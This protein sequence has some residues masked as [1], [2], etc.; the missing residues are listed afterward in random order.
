MFL[1]LPL[2][3]NCKRLLSLYL[4]QFCLSLRLFGQLL[5]LPSLCLEKL[6]LL[7]AEGHQLLGLA[8]LSQLLWRILWLT[9]S[10][11]LV[12]LRRVMILSLSLRMILSVV[13][14]TILSRRLGMI[15]TLTLKSMLLV[16]LVFVIRL[17]LKV[18]LFLLK[19]TKVWIIENL[20][21]LRLL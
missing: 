7:L 19:L 16:L 1:S 8:Q 3:G 15:L 21:F 10:G 17:L 14:D 12:V 6:F 4:Q 20:P 18:L 2:G 11:L 9:R 5:I 13:L